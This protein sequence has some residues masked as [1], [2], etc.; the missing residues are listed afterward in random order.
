MP[1]NG[2]ESQRLLYPHSRGIEDHLGTDAGR[3][4]GRGMPRTLGLSVRCGG[5]DRTQGAQVSQQEKSAQP[6]SA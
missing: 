2:T 4:A 1:E 3:A 5:V 6:V